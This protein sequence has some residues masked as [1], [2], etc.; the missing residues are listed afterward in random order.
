VGYR[1][2]SAFEDFREIALEFRG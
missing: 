1:M 2:G